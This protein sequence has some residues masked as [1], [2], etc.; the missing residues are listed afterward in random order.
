MTTVNVNDKDLRDLAIK[1]LRKKRDLQAHVLAYVTVNLLINVIWLLTTPG[2]F[3]WPVFP[4]LGWGIGL[5]FNIWDVYAPKPTE[6]T[7]EREMQR[8]K[9]HDQA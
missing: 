9:G 5:A 1:E 4:L 6:E 8:L 3:Y 7:I 2:G